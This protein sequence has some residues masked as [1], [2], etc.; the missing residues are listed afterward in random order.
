MSYWCGVGEFHENITSNVACMWRDAGCDLR[1]LNDK[2]GKEAVKPLCDAINRM[3]AD[4]EKYKEMN[5]P[6]GWGDYEGCLSYL[7]RFH[8]ACY[9]NPEE[10]ISVHC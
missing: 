4:P 5:P 10:I 9:S 2:K 3:K 8:D 7:M 1:E 6:N